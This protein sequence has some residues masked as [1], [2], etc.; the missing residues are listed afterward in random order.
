MIPKNSVYDADQLFENE[1]IK[2]QQI[3]KMPENF[4]DVN[5]LLR[6]SQ[7]YE[8][9]CNAECKTDK[10]V[11]NAVDPEKSMNKRFYETLY[12]WDRSTEKTN[13][14][15]QKNTPKIQINDTYETKKTTETKN[16]KP[17]KTKVIVI[18]K[19]QPSKNVINYTKYCKEENQ[20]RKILGESIFKSESDREPSK[21][22]EAEKT[23]TDIILDEFIKKED[24]YLEKYGE[25]EFAEEVSPYE[26][27][28]HF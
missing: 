18:K 26:E 9:F 1:L 20:K 21:K 13:E 28:H 5:A 23:D 15:E 4:V 16:D 11:E 24:E 25:I 7:E 22:P 8:L 19:F 12:E 17:S 2:K 14:T 10:Y 3:I 27:I 6:E